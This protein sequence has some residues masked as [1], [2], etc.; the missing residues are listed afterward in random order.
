MKINGL[1]IELLK[2]KLHHSTIKF[3]LNKVDMACVFI[4]D[5]FI[6]FVRSYFFTHFSILNIFVVSF[7]FPGYVP[8][9]HGGHWWLLVAN[10]RD[11]RFDVLSSTKLTDEMK[12]VTS[13]VV[14][15]SIIFCQ[16]VFLLMYF[17]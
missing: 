5:L 9:L 2:K 15:F 7:F 4:P 11:N 13:V 1:D 3:S 16:T 12:E 8:V 17:F 14:C 10:M 6:F